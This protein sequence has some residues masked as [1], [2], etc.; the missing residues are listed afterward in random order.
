MDN[1]EL[2]VRDGVLE[3]RSA[4][5]KQMLPTKSKL[6]YSRKQNDNQ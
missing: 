1:E 5:R 2:Y 4:A 3:E 6:R